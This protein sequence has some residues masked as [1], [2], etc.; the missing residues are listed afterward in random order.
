M[1]Y[2]Q[3]KLGSLIRHSGLICLDIDNVSTLKTCKHNLSNDPYCYAILISPSDNG[4]KIIVRVSCDESNHNEFFEALSSYFLK[5]YDLTVDRK[6]RDINRLCFLS[7]DPEI[8]INESALTFNKTNSTV[9]PLTAQTESISLTHRL[10]DIETIVRQI[11]ERKIDI[12]NGYENWLK[13]GFA[14]VDGLGEQGRQYFHR[15]SC[16]HAQYDFKQADK[17]FTSCL[18]ANRN[19]ITIKSFFQLAKDNGIKLNHI[20]KKRQDESYIKK[21]SKPDTNEGFNSKNNQPP[22]NSNLPLITKVENFLNENFEFRRNVINEKLEHRK[23]NDKSLTWQ[24]VNENAISRFLQKNYFK[25]SPNK[26]AE[27]LNSDFVNDYNPLIEYFENLP[28]WNRDKEPSYI[29]K[30]TSLIKAKDQERFNIQFKKML[31]RCVACSTVRGNTNPNFN[32]HVFVL[33]SAN[34]SSGKTTLCRWLCPPQLQ[35]YFLENISF[36]KDGVIALAQGFLINLDELASLSKYDNNVLKT[37]ISKASINE[38]LPY[39][40]SRKFYPRRANFVGTTNNIEFL[41]DETGNVRWLCHEIESINFGYSDL[42]SEHFVDINRLW[43]EAYARFI[44]G[45]EWQLSTQERIEN[46]LSNKTFQVIS[47]E[48]ELIISN[49]EA[50]EKRKEFFMT[51]SDIL[52]KLASK[53]HNIL[54]L[55]S[56]KLGAVLRKLNFPRGEERIGK[57]PVKGYYLKELSK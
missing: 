56:K 36:D 54:R 37:F 21:T 44:N 10:A 42:N 16:F 28:A 20:S 38:R 35:D 26:T 22:T 9:K 51:N 45:E 3:R 30:L 52:Q 57:Y 40:R 12:T 14:L 53:G 18:K 32:K 27:L 34:Q 46:E 15:L 33:V 55:T 48:E 8:Y 4:L 23:K 24:Q 19:G 31:I 2:G 1:F 17:Q 5:K 6:C 41:F 7:Y 11:E 47:E 39:G 50:T 49:F 43:A 13:L 25:Y 29:D